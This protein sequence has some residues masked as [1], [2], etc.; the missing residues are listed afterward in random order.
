MRKISFVILIITSCLLTLI[1]CQDSKKTSA[2]KLVREWLGKE[3]LLPKDLP[4]LYMD[5]DTICP[6]PSQKS[7]KI[8][9]YTDSVGCT[10]C[11]LN[12]NLWKIY[13]NDADSIAPGQVDFLFYFQPKNQRELTHLLRR[14]RLEKIIFMDKKSQLSTINKLPKEIDYQC[15][16]LDK[17]NKVLSIGNPTLNPQIWNI[18]KKLFTVETNL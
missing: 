12:L 7:F 6:K 2:E 10:S 9:V 3:I 1:S 4:C 11:Q 16:L 13:M 14:E 17:D 15:F 8:L 18:Y 5:K